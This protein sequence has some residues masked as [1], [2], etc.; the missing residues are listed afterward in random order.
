MSGTGR[1]LGAPKP[2]EDAEGPTGRLGLLAVGLLL[3]GPL[4]EGPL[5]PLLEGPLLLP[6]LV[7]AGGVGS[8]VVLLGPL[9]VGVAGSGVSAGVVVVVVVSAGVV[10]GA[11]VGGGVAAGGVVVAAAVSGSGVCSGSGAL[12]EVVVPA[13]S[14]AQQHTRQCSA[15]VEPSRV[16][17]SADLFH[18]CCGV[19]SV[20]QP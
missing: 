4:L 5:L 9:E 14:R 17:C 12:I 18:V 15:G 6:L 3:L 20:G 10:V 2:P 11:V 7:V 13:H 16:D 1:P 8:M 19:V